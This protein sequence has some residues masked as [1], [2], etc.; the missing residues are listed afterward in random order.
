MR[1]PVKGTINLNKIQIKANEIEITDNEI[2]I[3]RAKAKIKDIDNLHYGNT[4]LVQDGEL[5]LKCNK[6]CEQCPMHKNI[7]FEVFITSHT[8]KNVQG[9]KCCNRLVYS[10]DIK[11]LPFT[12]QKSKK[13]I[14]LRKQYEGIHE[15]FKYRRT[16]Y[17]TEKSI[18]EV[19]EDIIS[20]MTPS[21]EGDVIDEYGHRRLE[22]EK[23]VLDKNDFGFEV[24]HYGRMGDY[25]WTSTVRLHRNCD[26]KMMESALRS[27]F[28]TS[29]KI[30]I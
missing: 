30:K 5:L 26:M 20:C 1:I 11:D 12:R 29:F 3:N 23:I 18:E 22:L 8:F 17:I 6:E 7:Q 24:Y 16:P 14:E 10:E 15:K 9:H 2:I 28:R 21:V 27:K 25:G 4:T 19:V 13:A